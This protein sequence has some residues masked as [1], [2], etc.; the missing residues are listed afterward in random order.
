MRNLRMLVLQKKPPYHIRFF[1]LPSLMP[2]HEMIGFLI[3]VVLITYIPT[4][5][6]L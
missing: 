2:V 4:R 1:Q 5:T 3:Q 6:D